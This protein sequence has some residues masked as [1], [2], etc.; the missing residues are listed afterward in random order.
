[1]KAEVNNFIGI[2]RD[3]YPADFCAFLVDQF[4]AQINSGA[5]SN[6]QKSE[7]AFKLAKDDMQ[8]FDVT[9]QHISSFNGENPYDIL[10]EGIQ[11]TFD[12]YV[13][14]YPSLATYDLTCNCLKFQAT[15]DKGGYH[16]WHSE[17]SGNEMRRV[18]TFLLYL[19][20]L[21]ESS[22]GETEFLFQR[23]RVRP[24]ENTLVI[25]PAHFTHPHRGNPVYGEHIKYVLTSWFT[26]R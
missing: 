2:Y 25:W 21:P 24:E 3:L 18:L 6:R 13:D 22:N 23:T 1:M 16:I 4:V 5:G 19:N 8:L 11:Q 7:N 15:S 20:T 14:T 12:H 9:K 10:W 26:K 17:D